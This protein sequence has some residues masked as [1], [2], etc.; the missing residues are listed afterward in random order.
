MKMKSLLAF[1][2]AFAVAAS[3]AVAAEEDTPLAKEMTAMNKTLRALK[4]S[5]SDP[6][7]K[8]DNV[9]AVAKMKA[10]LAAAVK[11]EPAKTK[12]QPAA[13]KPAYLEKFKKQLADLDKAFD[14]LKAAI[15]KGDDAAIQASFEKL[16]DLKEKGHKDFAPDE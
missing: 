11:L 14:D 15:E 4:K 6:A 3:L 5:V 9:A 12:D 8:A 13:E 7:K 2:S 10:N 1:V 16:S